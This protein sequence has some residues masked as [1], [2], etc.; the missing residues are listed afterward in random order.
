MALNKYLIYLRKSRQDNENETIEEVLARHEKQLQE[1]AIKEFGA[2][3]DEKNIYREIVSGETIDDRPQINLL[4]ERMQNENIEGVLV[5][6]TSRLTRGDLLDCGRVV[7]LFKYTNTLIITPQKT[8]NLDDKFDRKFFEMEL[9]K[10]NDYL[11][12][13]K[14]ILAR[15]RDASIK[16]GN[17]IGSVAP[18]GYKLAKI[19]KSPTLEIDETE[20]KYVKLAFELYASG[21]GANSIANRLNELG[22][23]PRKAD[24]FISTAIRQMLENPVYI[25]KIKYKFKPQKKVYEDNKLIKKRTRNYNCELINGKHKAII[26]EELYNKCKVQKGKV[27]REKPSTELINI[28]ASILKCK[29]CGRAIGLRPQNKAYNGRKRKDRYYCTSGKYCLCGSAN[30]D[31]VNEAIINALKDYLNDFQI[32]IANNTNQQVKTLET[33]RNS[34]ELDLKKLD[35]KQNDLYDLL[36]DGIYTKEVFLMR[37]DKLKD[38]RARLEKAINDIVIPPTINY[39]EKIVSLHQAIEMI[40]DDSISPKIKNDFLKEVIEVIYYDKVGNDKRHEAKIDL[41]IILK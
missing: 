2:K 17:Y 19:D 32:K 15:G 13:T 5:I 23:K 20:A 4:F 9:T 26:S 22:A 36:E 16:E 24:R 11:E 28:F 33:L 38:E 12:Y 25:G 7:H 3:I 31:S 18:Y 30:V 39:E 41:E 6:E 35:K 27:T 34:L 14:E 8:Y 37:N 10:G 1:Y 40:K 21:M 29:K